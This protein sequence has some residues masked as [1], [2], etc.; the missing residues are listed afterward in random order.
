MVPLKTIPRDDR[1]LPISCHGRK[2]DVA[3]SLDTN[4][5]RLRHEGWIP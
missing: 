1:D 5:F 3:V 4:T 2:N